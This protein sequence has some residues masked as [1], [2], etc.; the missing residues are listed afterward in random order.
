MDEAGFI[1]SSSESFPLR[2]I[3]LGVLI[4]T[5]GALAALP[6][7]RLQIDSDASMGPR[8]AT[9]PTQSALDLPSLG[10]L[11]A[12]DIE[13]TP[14]EVPLPDTLPVWRSDARARTTNRR[15]DA[16]LSFDDLMVPITDP[17]PIRRRF[18]ATTS[19]TDRRVVLEMPPL[20]A[21]P[22]TMQV[23]LNRKIAAS[24][25]LPERPGSD[26]HTPTVSGSLASTP[27]QAPSGDRL[28]TPTDPPNDRHWIRQP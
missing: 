28:P 20:D 6:F 17:E 18:S 1:P 22:P 10:S 14:D 7:R 21:L 11:A 13:R 3:T 9:G 5:G 27:W 4:V 26:S 15:M 23:E 2:N 19:E 24:P 8:E 25:M 12:S 16:P